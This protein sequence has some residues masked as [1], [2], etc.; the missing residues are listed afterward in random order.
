MI[1]TTTILIITALPHFTMVQHITNLAI[2]VKLVLAFKDNVTQLANAC[3]VYLACCD[4]IV[5]WTMNKNY[6]TNM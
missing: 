1:C 2:N 3:Q 6:Y 5:N 4:I